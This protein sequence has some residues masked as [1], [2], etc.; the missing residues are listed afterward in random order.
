VPRRHATGISDSAV[1]ASASASVQSMADAGAG[2]MGEK[3]G[4]LTTTKEEGWAYCS[5]LSL[6]PPPP[7]S[8]RTFP[9]LAD[10]G[11]AAYAESPALFLFLLGAE[12][13]GHHLFCDMYRLL[14]WGHIVYGS[15]KRLL[16][17]LF[18]A[19][20]KFRGLWS[21]ACARR[22]AQRQLNST[23]KLKETAAAMR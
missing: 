7:L 17:S 18:N 22:K 10:G 11:D 16:A 23:A 1:T 4:E 8:N 14:S 21:A 5:P 20:T 2:L 15:Y 9:A 19:R 3:S 13:A 12:G 6:P